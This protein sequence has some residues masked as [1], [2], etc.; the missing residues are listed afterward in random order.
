M[1]GISPASP[2]RPTSLNSPLSVT[3]IAATLFAIPSSAN[4]SLTRVTL[5]SLNG[6]PTRLIPGVRVMALSS[7][8]PYRVAAQPNGDWS[9]YTGEDT[10]GGGQRSIGDRT[11][12]CISKIAV[13]RLRCGVIGDEEVD[14]LRITER[15]VEVGNRFDGLCHS[16]DGL[17]LSAGRGSG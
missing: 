8:R 10:G 11:S 5:E 6:N 12:I 14:C 16:V 13:P 1:T 2:A 7:V 17:L 9:F 15:G 4:R 3:T